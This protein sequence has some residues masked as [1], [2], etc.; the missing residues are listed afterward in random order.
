MAIEWSRQEVLTAI[1]ARLLR[2]G[3]VTD[4]YSGVDVMA[5]SDSMLVIFRW[6]RDP[7]TYAIKVEFP[8]APESSWPGLPVTSADE[9]AADVAYR[10][11]EELLTGL[12]R[13]SRRMIRDGYV[14]LDTH[15][16]P[17][18]CPA[19]FFISSV[20][21]G[22]RV[23]PFH[24][25]PQRDGRERACSVLG[26]PSTSVPPPASKVGSW[27]AKAG[28]DVAIPRQLI[29]EAKLACWLQARVDNARRRPFVGHAV[30]SW[31]DEQHT[32]ARLNLV[33]IQPGV[34][35]EVRDA[36]VRLAVCEVAEAGA[37][38]MVT[39]ID[40]PGLHE[41]GFR[42]ANGGGL[43]LHTGSAEA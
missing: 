18:V 6:R 8:T 1:R 37:L 5:E 33:H 23:A 7:N 14:V 26:S 40:A 16:A 15:D 13:R 10:V 22:D 36:L 42:P 39:T 12:V 35:S 9:W 24:S 2:A 20:P 28:M 19:G 43:T 27:L 25:P 38:R 17:D 11:G 4:G 30:A 31:E 32:I 41:L 21:L 34:P 3:A 29:V